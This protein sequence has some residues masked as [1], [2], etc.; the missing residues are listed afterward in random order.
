MK[1][2][3]AHVVAPRPLVGYIRSPSCRDRSQYS[4]SDNMISQLTHG[5]AFSLRALGGIVFLLACLA[6]SS[7][8]Q[9]TRSEFW[10]ELDV[11]WRMDAITRFLFM[12]APTINRQEAYGE[13]EWGA[14]V[15]FGVAPILRREFRETYDIDR[16]RFL[17]FRAGVSYVSNLEFN[18]STFS[19]WRGVVEFTARALLPYDILGALR[20][21][22]DL[23]W[24]D[25]V[26]ST[27]IRER[28][29]VERE[30]HLTSWLTLVP[31][32]S[33]ELFYDSRYAIWNRTQTKLGVGIPVVGPVV[34]DLSYVY[35]HDIRSQPTY[36]NALGLAVNFFF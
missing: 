12:A 21:R 16:F 17:R 19:E 26:Y 15:E 13:G 35:Q 29:G 2:Q 36:I 14:F 6:V 30:T 1:I 10:P 28:L 7:H 9:Q 33:F 25:G 22:A 3:V 27:R 8:A 4:H 11:Y 23:R 20:T 18:E 24:V 32:A 5:R 34:V 31:F